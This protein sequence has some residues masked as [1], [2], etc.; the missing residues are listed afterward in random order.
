MCVF[1]VILATAPLFG[2]AKRVALVI[3]NSSYLKIQALNNP[4]R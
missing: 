1:V 2:Q 4:G 3:G